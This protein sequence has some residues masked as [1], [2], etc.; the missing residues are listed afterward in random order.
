MV[1]KTSGGLVKTSFQIEEE[2][3][4]EVDRLAGERGSNISRS[5]VIRD[6]V[7]L[8]SPAYEQQTAVLKSMS[9]PRNIK[10]G[11]A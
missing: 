3:L 10:V 9:P 4:L 2:L 7:R 8:G 11:A 5:D 1:S 6:L